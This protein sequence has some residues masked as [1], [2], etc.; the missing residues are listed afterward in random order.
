M[1]F[2][3]KEPPKLEFVAAVL[4]DYLLVYYNVVLMYVCKNVKYVVDSASIM[5]NL[6]VLVKP[7]GTWDDNDNVIGA[8]EFESIK[9]FYTVVKFTPFG[10]GRML[11]TYKMFVEVLMR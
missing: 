9:H 5:V 11:S 6:R 8:I 3:D 7:K 4:V 10:S 2:N 1:K